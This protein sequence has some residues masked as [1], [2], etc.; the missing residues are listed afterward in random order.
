MVRKKNTVK[1]IRYPLDHNPVIDYYNKIVSGEILVSHKVRET[2]K[3]LVRKIHD[4]K[5][6]YKYDAKKA[7]KAI[8]F[9]ENFCK[10]S[11]GEWSGK[12][13]FL[14]LWQK[15]L[16]A[17]TFGMVSKETDY[18]MI[19][20]LVLVIPRKAGKSTLGSAIANYML[21]ADNEG[22]SEV[23]AI[24]TKKDQA[25]RVWDESVKMIKKSPVLSERLECRIGEIRYP[26]GEATYK[27]LASDSNS[28]DGLNTHG[29]FMDEIHAWKDKNLYDVIVDSMSTRKQPLNFIMTTAGYVRNGIYDLKYKECEDIINGYS[30]GSYV[31]DSVLPII[32]EL[33]DMEEIHNEEMWYKANPTLG[34]VKSLDFIRKQY[35]KPYR[36][37]LTCQTY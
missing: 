13:I 27:P 33:D 31:D 11:K 28:L 34:T 18:R 15:A 35:N 17:A 1:L 30:D 4:P 2:Y 9:V 37:L 16:L 23:Y 24:A 21:I 14:E 36:I 20:E 25:K 10:H 22:G 29:S 19:F 8:E 3:E 12:P 32:Y 6:R 26:M 7:N 5:C